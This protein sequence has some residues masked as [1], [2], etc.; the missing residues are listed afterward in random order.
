MVENLSARER[1]I[2]NLL[3]KGVSPKEIAQKLNISYFT[4]DFH[5]TNLY[6]KLDVHSIQELFAK[7]STNGK[8]PPPEALEAEATAPV[9]PANK[10]KLK[11]LLPV[12]VVIIAFTVLLLCLYIGKSSVHSAPKGE[13]IPVNNLGFSTTSDVK[14]GGSSTSEVFITQEKIDGTINSVL[15]IKTNVARNGDSTVV[16]AMAYTQ[17]NDII[18]RLRQANG[19]RFKA[20]GDGK[21]WSVEFETP[22]S[23]MRKNYACYTYMVRTIRDQVIAVDVPYSSLFLPEWVEHTFDFDKKTIKDFSITANFTQ[24]YGSA[25][26]Q[27]F[28]FEIY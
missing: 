8:A 19:I 18:Q 16:Y 5:R 10:K 2:F 3:L 13:I 20:L 28:D 23:R 4:V 17:K 22:E 14:I 9:S 27:I 11:I 6:K 7:Y 26:L 1:E 12:G 25:F 24:G 15:N 21:L